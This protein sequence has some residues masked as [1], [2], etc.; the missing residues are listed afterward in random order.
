MMITKPNYE[1]LGNKEVCI[2]AKEVVESIR[3]C[4]PMETYK[5]LAYRADV[6][7]Q[8]VLRW[9]SVGRA[10]KAAMQRLI[11]SLASEANYDKVLLKD[12]TPAQ[13]RRQCQV[14]GWDSVINAPKQGELFMKIEDA[15][16]Q[17]AEKLQDDSAWT[18][19]LDDTN[20]G[21]YGVQDFDVSIDPQNIWIDFPNMSFNF[22]EVEFDFTVRI[23]GSREDDSIDEEY[24]RIACGQGQFECAG[25]SVSSIYGLEII[26]DLELAGDGKVV[27]L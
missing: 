13:L 20:P 26:C 10:E 7:I 1:Q 25:G 22:K 21:H 4:F 2:N 9:V 15:Q 14:I 24:H 18:E 12:A 19:V 3:Q 5:T 23:G 11:E 27:R 6:H 8:S 16:N 17:I